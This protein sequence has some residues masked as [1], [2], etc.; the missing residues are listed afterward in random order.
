M[1]SQVEYNRLKNFECTKIVIEV[2]N[3]ME[4]GNISDTYFFLAFFKQDRAE[5]PLVL[6]LK[7]EIDCIHVKLWI[8][9]CVGCSSLKVEAC[10]GFNCN[11][12]CPPV[13]M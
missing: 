6:R 4:V 12:T 2:K 8:T 3:N 9:P 7:S 1:F 10:V 13:F 11:R 5:F